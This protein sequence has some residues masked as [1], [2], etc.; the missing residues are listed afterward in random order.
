[1]NSFWNEAWLTGCAGNC[2]HP[3]GKCRLTGWLRQR[4]WISLIGKK[5]SAKQPKRQTTCTT[6]TMA[7]KT[8]VVVVETGMVFT[9]TTN[10]NM[11]TATSVVATT[12][13]RHHKLFLQAVLIWVEDN[14]TKLSG[15]HSSGL[16]ASSRLLSCG[17]F[18]IVVWSQMFNAELA[19]PDE[20]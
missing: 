15:A 13:L 5:P 2:S 9:T 14:C 16:G 10:S 1:M 12:R 11:A 19:T 3:V 7:T 17:K 6:A 8:L 20:Q 18:C 4:E